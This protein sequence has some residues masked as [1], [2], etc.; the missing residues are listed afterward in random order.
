MAN[1]RRSLVINFLTSSGAAV[2]QFIV[3]ILLAR[4]LSPSEIGVY[5][6]AVVFVNIAHIF[7]DFGVATY[8]QREPD[9]TT[10]KIR[11]AIGVMFASTWLIA[12]ILYLM[13]AG[14]GEWFHE[15]G[16]VP[17]MRLLALGFLIIPFGAITHAM[18]VRELAADKQAVVSA[19]GTL[20]YC[21][22]C[23]GLAAMGCGTMSI[24]WANLISNVVAA[25]AYI[26]YRPKGLPWLPSFRHWRGI[27]NFGMGTLLTNCAT[28][29]NNSIPDVL[30]GKLGNAR[31]VGLFSRANSTVS[32]FTYAAG[33]TISY[34]AVSY[35]SQSHHRGESL[36]PTLRRATALLTGIGWPAYALTAILGREI[37]IALYG[38]KWVDCMPA[39]VPLSLAAA[40]SMLFQYTPVALTAIGRPYLGAFPV[41]ITL[42][43]RIAFGFLL[44]D[45][46]LST[47]AWAICFA[48]LAAAPMAAFQQHR[49]FGFGLRE[50]AD[51]VRP[52]LVVTIL[53]ITACE[54]LNYMLPGSLT[55]TARLLILALPLIT[56]WYMALRLT[57]HP[58][59][60][61]VHH[62][63]AGVKSRLIRLG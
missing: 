43:F 60:G 11:S 62:L 3:S 34:G 36:V 46:T 59:V 26:P 51:S 58:L 33:S 13:S 17:I 10:E 24:G 15:P 37:V 29:I 35:L 18:L 19:A 30:L 7:R 28:A 8:L 9:L 56:V 4:M 38:E 55:A 16:I 52:S 42:F 2:L 20:S 1:L 21:I 27:A 54:G 40:I 44:F 49:Y 61:E 48:T 5:S 57:R 41:S 39:I 25:I 22:S 32:I 53:C 47:F 50:L 23:L 12:L 31:N 45:G 63:A 14:I 6:M